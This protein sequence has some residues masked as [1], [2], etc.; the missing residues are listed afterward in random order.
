M[1]FLVAVDGSET[2]K[3]ALKQTLAFVKQAGGEVIAITV[4][5]YYGAEFEL[6]LVGTT[7]EV[8]TGPAEAVLT[9]AREAAKEMGV[10][11]N[12]VMETGTVHQA[13]V[14]TAT[15]NDVDLIVMGRRGLTRFERALMGSVT[16]R[17]IGYSPIDVLV[18][19]RESVLKWDKVLLPVDGSKYSDEA[20][21]R[22]IELTKNYGGKLTILT[23][24]DINPELFAIAPDIADQVEMGAKSI[25][26]EAKA[27][28]EKAGIDAEM[29][30]VEGEPYEKIIGV[31]KDVG[32]GL[33]CMG[34]HGRTGIGR[35]MMGSVTERVIGEAT[36]PVLV[37]KTS[38]A[39]PLIK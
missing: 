2:G 7:E 35:L 38:Q 32:A 27:L 3:N 36:T 5:F 4:P 9:E 24:V 21:K 31:A 29:V 1:R 13:I 25:V 17:V 23:V 37:V 22:A 8:F 12:T 14:K 10:E 16:S 28:A 26:D 18:I 15:A 30:L 20:A 39:A 34:S 11:I 33:I 6:G 19:P